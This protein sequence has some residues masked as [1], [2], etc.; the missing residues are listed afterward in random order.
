[1]VVIVPVAG[2]SG[3]PSED[4]GFSRPG[5]IGADDDPSKVATPTSTA[6]AG[7]PVLSGRW[8]TGRRSW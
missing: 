7:L 5:R 2:L 1:M 6:V 3:R 8:V 4:I